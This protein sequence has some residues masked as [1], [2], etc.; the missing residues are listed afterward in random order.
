VKNKEKGKGFISCTSA[1]KKRTTTGEKIGQQALEI[2][3]KDD[4][5]DT[6]I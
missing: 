6:E 1:K 5:D 4:A 2:E 3:Q